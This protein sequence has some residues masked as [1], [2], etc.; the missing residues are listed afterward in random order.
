MIIINVTDY[1]RVKLNNG[2]YTCEW[3]NGHHWS[4]MPIDAGLV[5]KA[6][7]ILLQAVQGTV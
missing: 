7:A 2:K 5:Q 1:K 4:W 3:Y 6:K